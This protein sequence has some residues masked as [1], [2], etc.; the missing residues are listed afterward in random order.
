MPARKPK[1]RPLSWFARLMAGAGWCSVVGLW[2]AAGSQYV[3]PVTFRYVGVLGLTFPMFL[4]GTVL[5]FVASLLFARRIAWITLLG[6]LTCVMSIRRYVPVNI[7]SPPPKHSLRVLTYNTL[8]FGSGAH[9]EKDRNIVAQY[10]LQSGADVICFQEGHTSPTE[11]DRHIT[12]L[13]RDAYPYRDTLNLNFNNNLG[14][15]SKYPIV[16]REVVYRVGFN[17]SVAYEIVLKQGDTLLVVNNHL[18]SNKLGP[19]DREMYKKIVKDPDDAPMKQGI[20]QLVPKIAE[21]TVARAVQ[22]DSVARYVFAHRRGRSTVVCGDFNDTPISY[23][24][25]T[26]AQDLDDAFTQSGR[27]LGISYNQNRFYFRIDNILISP[28]QKA[29]NCTVDRSIKDSDH[30][31][32]WCYIGKQ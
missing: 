16:S 12:P 26:I 10:M 7:P 30:Y 20:R 1:R 31:P 5:L 2:I 22:A 25:R 13:L 19:A 18:A 3:S 21:A 27:G 11:W 14:C 28:N 6:L 32:I 8:Q 4:G 24:H 23:T 29:Y 9:D 15:F 17:A